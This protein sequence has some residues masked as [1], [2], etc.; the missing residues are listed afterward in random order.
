V[1][2]VMRNSDWNSNSWANIQN[3]DP[4]SVSKQ[5]D[6]GYTIGGP[7]GRPGGDNKIFFFYSHEFRPRSAGGQTQRYRLPTAL[8]KAGDFSQ[9]LDNNGNPIPA[10]RDFTT[11]G[12]FAGQ[13]IPSE[14]IY[15]VGL[16]ILNLWPLSPNLVQ[17]PGTNYNTEYVRPIVDTLSYQP[18]V[19]LDYQ[20]SPA[21]RFSWRFTGDNQRATRPIE[22][23]TIPGFNDSLQFHTRPW[24]ITWS[25]SVNYTINPTTFIEGTYGLAMNTLGNPPASEMANRYNAGLGALP[26]LFP[27]AGTVDPRYYNYQVM[28]QLNLPIWRDGQIQ[29]TPDFQWGNRIGA[30]PPSILYPG[31]LNINRTQDVAI[32]LT[33]VLGRHTVKTGFYLNHSY[34]AQNLSAGGGARFEGVLNFGNDNNNPIDSG[35]GYANALLGIFS[36]YQQQSKFIEGSYLYNQVDWF[37]QDNWKVNNRLTLDYGLRFVYQQPQYDQYL[38]SSNFFEDLWDPASAPRLYLPGCV[39]ASPCSGNNRQARNP[40]NNQLL[41]PGSSVLIGQVVPNSGNALNGIVPAGQ[42]PN[43]KYNYEWPTIAYSP[44]FGAAYDLTG[45]QNFVIRGGVGLF[46]DRPN[47]NTVFAQSGNPPSSTNTIVRYGQLQNLGTGITSEGVPQLVT[48]EYDADIPASVQWNGGVQMTLPWASSLDVSYVGQHG[49]NLLQ[50]V[51]INSVDFGTAFTDAA[52]DP[53][54]AASSTPGA[55]AYTTDLLRP[56]RGLGQINRNWTK[57]WNT[58]HSVQ[59]SFNRRFRGG[60][61]AGLNWT[62]TI[63]DKGNTGNPLRIDHNADGSFVVRADQEEADKLLNDQG[64]PTHVFKGNFVWDLPD[65]NADT[66]ALRVVGAVLNNWQLSG[67]YTGGGA[68]GYAPTFSYQS[69]G[70]S[71]NLTGTP[72]YGARIRVVPGVDLGSGCS[73]NQYA[74]FNAAAFAG[75]VTPSVGL[76]S[77]RNLLRECADNTW[78]IAIARNFPLGGG[79]LIQVRAEM[80]NA[81][82]TVIYSG[83]ETQLQL[84]SPTNQ[85]V[86]NPQ[87]LPDGRVD[88]DRLLP[89]DAGF[90][91]VTSAQALRSAQVQVRFSF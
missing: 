19:R 43:N 2:D 4:K 15:P 52:R 38:Q 75:P 62:Y 28:E 74:Q 12:T 35:F 51:D 44:R 84:T 14:R 8:E 79:R 22:P 48:F 7:V 73:D 40:L 21:L 67:V 88:P 91:A 45:T 63:S 77:G 39:G 49:Y 60:I 82:N 66:T 11:G 30:A 78:D 57:S 54:L 29:V 32:N 23:G 31:F 3:G 18:G 16:A 50:N 69:G 53:T 9:S 68:G 41:G 36:S 86:R 33:K 65:L 6:W 87:H 37:V 25:G 27:D 76:E 90:G 59:T 56:Y 61:S 46:Y 13:I 10:L 64:T 71:V 20:M 85:T 89:N 55:T 5:T 34:K 70:S 72:S 26:L 83:V 58:F 1:Y 42:S 81:F 24:R 17:Q 80:F 47:G